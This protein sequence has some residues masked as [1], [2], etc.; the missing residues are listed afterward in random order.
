[1]ARKLIG[2]TC[3]ITEPKEKTPSRQ[4]LNRA[5]TRAIEQAG[6]IPVI[7]PVTSDAAVAQRYLDV[8]DGLLLSGGADIAPQ[9][10]GQT[11]H[12]TV[13]DVELDRDVTEL[14]LVRAALAQDMPLFAICRGIQTLNVALGGTLYQDLPTEHPSEINHR[15]TDKGLTRDAFSHDMLIEPNSRLRDLVNVG[16]MRINSLHHQAVRDVAEG[17]VV[18]GRAPDGVI[19]AAEMPSKRYVLAVQFHPEET[20]IHDPHTR[21]LFAAFVAVL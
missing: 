4:Q 2:I 15:Q 1:M 9:R 6:G 7:L 19:E 18:T 14:A 5:Y 12:P 10:Y 21:Q 8:I 3:G 11:P 20:A 13:N 16:E 17:L